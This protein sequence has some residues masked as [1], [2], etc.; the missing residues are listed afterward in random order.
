MDQRHASRPIDGP[1]D[2][3][4]IDNALAAPPRVLNFEPRLEAQ[5]RADGRADRLRYQRR[6]SYIGLALNAVSLVT[7]AE[8]VPDVYRL[9]LVMAAASTAVGSILVPVLQQPRLP[10]WL[11]DFALMILVLPGV[12]M[13]VIL[14]VTTHSADKAAFMNALPLYIMAANVC[15]QQRFAW[16]AAG[17]T[18]AFCVI[19]IGIM[20]GS[21]SAAAAG[22][23]AS[24]ALSAVL[25]SLTIGHRL[26]WQYRRAWLFRA[27]DALSNTRLVA[28]SARLLAL[29]ERDG[30]TGLANRRAIDDR[31]EQ[32]WATCTADDQPLGVIMLDVDWFKRFNDHYGH[33]EGDSCLR[34]VGA[35]I[36][37]HVR[38]QSDL[39]GRYG[40]EEFI[41][42]LPGADAHTSFGI[43]E[44]VCEAIQALQIPHV[45]G[46]PGAFVTASLGVA[47]AM[48]AAG[49][50]IARLL[51]AAD[52]ALYKAKR[53]GRARVACAEMS[54]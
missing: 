23:Q 38:R 40:G 19:L 25:L 24:D 28:L 42:I 15:L 16:A 34:A 51:I 32:A 11:T 3:A 48:P 37:E 6:V 20:T 52:A 4:L 46:P 27:R 12:T 18:V 41:L 21:I 8:M 26:E 1:E 54:G 49:G 10:S 30:L 14:F 9:A 2:A 43:A 13:Q 36:A 45:A 31:L 17:S 47:I 53:S 50:T 22:L 7:A 33:P 29:S 39:A 44:R 5:F 35:V